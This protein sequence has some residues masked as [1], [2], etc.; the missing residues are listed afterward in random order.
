MKTLMVALLI[1]FAAGTANAQAKPIKIIQN[2]DTL[3]TTN[4]TWDADTIYFMKG[5][6]YV[7]NGATLTIQ[8]GTVVI[9]DTIK[10][11]TLIITTGSK[12]HAVGTPSCPIVFTSSKAP[13]R[14][15][16]GDW[17]GVILLGLAATNNPGGTQYIEG[18]PQ[19]A[20]TQFGGGAN[21]NTHDNSGEMEYVRIEFAGVALS[22][23]NEING[24]T[25]GAVGDG[26]TI[27]FVQVS[28]SNDD[29]FEWFGGSVNCKHLIAFRGID[30]DFDTDNGYNGKLQ[31]GMGLRDP[32]VA[33]VSGSKAFE[34]DNNAT[35]TTDLPQT[36]AI[37]S[38]FTCTAGSDS[39]TN[40]L[41]TA[42]AHI[43]RNSHLNIY[44]SIIMGFPEG[45]LIDGT[46]TQNNVLADTMVEHNIIGNKYAPKN[47]VTT[48]LPDP[49]VVDR[50]QN[51]ADNRYFTGN[52]QVLLSNPYNL[53]NPNYRPATGSPALTGAKFTSA[54][55]SDPFFTKTTYV[56]AFAKQAAQNWATIWVNFKPTTTDYSQVNAN[57]TTAFAVANVVAAAAAEDAI[58]AKPEASVYPNPAKGSFNVS[59]TGFNGNVTIK[60][61]NMGG[62]TVYNKQFTAG[63][64]KTSINVN[65]EKA[66]AGLYFVTVTNG[67]QTTTQKVN[68]IQ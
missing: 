6:V 55:L 3:I 20:L 32:L 1:I 65:L 18:L 4:K 37:F 42:G 56:G 31:F 13:G 58:A 52:T 17:G 10:K 16:R 21:P 11:G 14:R 48:P 38:N 43:R 33:D 67:K 41:F 47:V 46:T 61:A 24:L 26:T 35:G 25:F 12:I 45:L 68:I 22:P 27:D 49:G 64:S 66:P 30:D 54:G 7:T 44:N 39:A 15:A 62:S 59:L 29:S 50:L 63:L 5:K 51:H 36:K 8:P 57:C 23:N 19:F 2:A 9:G 34:S 60:V 40:S 28:Y 53:N